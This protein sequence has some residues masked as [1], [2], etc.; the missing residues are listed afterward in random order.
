[1]AASVIALYWDFENLHASLL[2]ERDGAGAYTATKFRPQDPVI[3][4]EPVL[5]FAASLGRVAVNRAYGNW[6]WLA[7]YRH[8]L[9]AHGLDLVQLFPLGTG[10]KNG[11]D[12][13]LAVDAVDD[14]YRFVHV[15]HVVVVGGDSDYLSLAQRVRQHGRRIVG[16][17]AD[18]S[19][20]RQWVA[21]CDQFVRYHELAGVGPGAG[22]HHSERGA[23]FDLA[24]EAVTRLAAET[25]QRWVVKAAVKPMMT[26]I[27]P[28]FDESH[29]GFGSFNAFLVAVGGRLVERIGEFDHEIAVD[30]E[31]TTIDLTEVRPAADRYDRVLRRANVRLPERD[32]FWAAVDAI[33]QLAGGGVVASSFHQLEAD[34]LRQLTDAGLE[35]DDRQVRS[36]RQVLFKLKLFA[37]LGEEVGVSLVAGLDADLGAVVR[38]ELLAMVADVRGRAR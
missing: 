24:V 11:A 25:G 22:R 37:L 16:V 7:R 3:E 4:I 26:R 30:T 17:G 23:A 29:L 36:T 14:L 32:V 20:H 27:E 21:A 28:S 38:R 12:I 1:M 15:T 34:V 13:R 10:A 6:Q 9:Q 19:S 33:G 8:D 5:A 35:V 2:D 18:G 31:H